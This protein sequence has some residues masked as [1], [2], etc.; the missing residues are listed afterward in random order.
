MLADEIGIIDH[1]KLLEED[2][3]AELEQRN[4]KYIHFILS[5]TAH[6]ARILESSFHEEN[7]SIQDDHDLRIYNLDLPVNKLIAV[8]VENGLEISEAHTYEESLEDYFKKVTGSNNLPN[9]ALICHNPSFQSKP[10]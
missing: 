7:F 6:A 8:F 5:D 9:S 10:Q 2:S 1:G 4:S 3:L